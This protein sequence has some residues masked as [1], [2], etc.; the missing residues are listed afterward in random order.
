MGPA[1]DAAGAAAN[2]PDC[3]FAPIH[4]FETQLR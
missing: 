4:H 3:A 2:A 1:K